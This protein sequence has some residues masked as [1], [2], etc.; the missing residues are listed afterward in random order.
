[1][2]DWF[3]I[4]GRSVL[5]PMT[6]G[7]HYGPNSVDYGDYDSAVTNGLIEQALTAA[8]TATS[9][10]SELW[11]QVSQQSMKDAVFIPLVQAGVPIL[12]SSNVMNPV[13]LP[14]NEDYDITNVWLSNA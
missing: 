14:I 9:Q 3:G 12:K 4:N 1:V 10:I 13:Y 5:E 7:S 11:H 8:P 6:D 2:P